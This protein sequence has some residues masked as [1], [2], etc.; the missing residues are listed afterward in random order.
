MPLQEKNKK[1]NFF[2][3]LFSPVDLTTGKIYKVILIFALPIIISYVLQQ[4]YTISDAAIIG[5]T[6]SADEV[7]GVNDTTSLVF[8]FLQFAFGASAGFCVITA[9]KIGANDEAGA[10]KSFAA[11]IVLCTGISVVLTVLSLFLLDPMLAWLNVMPDSGVIYQSAHLYCA[12]IFAGIGAQMFYN[13]ICSFLRSLGDSFTPLVF[14]F[15]S[16]LL[17]IALDLMFI[18]LFKWGVFGA[19]IATVAAQ[20]ISTLAC[21]VYTFVKYKFLRL[22]AEDFR[23]SKNELRAHLSQGLPLGLQFSVLAIGIIVMQSCVVK[24]DIL[25]GTMISNAAQNGFGAANKLNNFMMTP[26]MA[27]GSAMTSFNAQSLGAGYKDRVKKGSNQSVL[28]MLIV[29]AILIG[30]GFLCTVNGAYLYL[31]LS[32]DKVTNETIRYGNNLL[33]VDFSLYILLAMIFSMRNCVQGIGK[34]EFVLGAGAAELIARVTICLLLPAAINGGAID[35]N[36][37]NAAYIALCFADPL[38]WLAS[39]SVLIFPYVKHILRNDYKYLETTK[40]KQKQ[41]NE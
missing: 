9:R 35:A 20:L 19:A 23:L 8:I 30:I 41:I 22:H 25:D 2:R 27:L 7:A 21:F 5:Q 39:D 34:S 4:I 6:L 16:T 31:F 24:F 32:A 12:V 11:Q 3:K 40:T 38:A 17:N 29:C 14:L 37:S 18:I 28:M 33:Y 26:M 36:A 15:F 1:S 13:F 10:R